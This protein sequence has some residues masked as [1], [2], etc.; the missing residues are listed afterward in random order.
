MRIQIGFEGLVVACALASS[1]RVQATPPNIVFILTDDQ[2]LDS[3]DIPGSTNELNCFTPNL[4]HFAQQGRVFP[5]TRVNPYCS[6][7]RA[8]LLTGRQALQTGVT[9]VLGSL[10]PQP[11]GTKLS[12]QT[13]E[14]CISEVLQDVGYHTVLVDKWHVG[15]NYDKGQMPLDQGFNRFLAY[16]FIAWMDDP[17][18]V[19]DEH[20]T[21][22]VDWV[23]ERVIERPDPNQPYAAFVWGIDPHKRHDITGR[24]N[25]LWWKVHTDLLPSGEPYYKPDPDEDTNLDRYRAVVESIDTELAR[26][27]QEMGVVDANLNYIPESNTVVFFMSDNGTV[28]EVSADP[29]HAKGT[30]YDAGIRVP[31]FV[32]GEGVPAD[33]QLSD[34]LISHTD[35]YDTVCDIIDA[36]PAQRGTAPREGQSFADAIGWSAPLPP[37]TVQIS[38]VGDLDPTKHR[39]TITNGQYK[40]VS[41]GGAVGF[42]DDAQAEF[43]DLLADPTERDNLLLTNM[44]KVQR[45]TL[46]VMRNELAA[47]WGTAVCIPQAGVEVDIPLTHVMCV[48]STNSRPPLP[49]VPVGHEV[50]GG[51]STFESRILLRFDIASLDA[52][53]PPGKDVDDISS[54]QIIVPFSADSAAVDETD[55]APLT[56]HPAT[57]DWVRY[58][59]LMWDRLRTA[60][61]GIYHLG[62][63]DPA[64]HIIPSPRRADGSLWGLPMPDGSLVCFGT[65][66]SLADAVRFWHANPS[67]NFGAVVM[68]TPLSDVNGD[69]QV[70]F[71]PE[72][73]VLR[74]RLAN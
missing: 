37:R 18:R 31:F 30:I 44:N 5:Q 67:M 56:I 32:F 72:G 70:F 29:N 7:T 59:N 19:G 45:D 62:D 23:V 61:L 6:P 10:D 21:T 27:L 33:G 46:W 36:T 68:S 64:P 69:Q 25:H 26:M 71:R 48:T 34:R 14:R 20:I 63:F 60:Y 17:I 66:T 57:V 2:G 49:V 8:G 11:D 28:R 35:F 9:G 38:S 1:A 73:A 40:L 12:L 52:L 55:T 24:E 41:P 39:V 74:V 22:M 51:G 43:Y 65:G 4:R 54:A 50:A 15:W 16:G 53:L 47:R 42:Y 3:I 58:P 13:Y